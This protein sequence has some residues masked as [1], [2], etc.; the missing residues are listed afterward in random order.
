ML[1]AEPRRETRLRFQLLLF[2]VTRKACAE[3]LSWDWRQEDENAFCLLQKSHPLPSASA[4]AV[5]GFKSKEIPSL[6]AGSEIGSSLF[7]EAFS[8]GGCVQ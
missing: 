6:L 1:E 2:G 3:R 5:S 4:W 7:S 8:L